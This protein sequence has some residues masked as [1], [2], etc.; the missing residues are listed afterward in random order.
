MFTIKGE[1]M[2]L[3]KCTSWSMSLWMSD[4][5]LPAD[6]KGLVVGEL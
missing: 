4:R 6:G 1:W 5:K 2:E 3:R